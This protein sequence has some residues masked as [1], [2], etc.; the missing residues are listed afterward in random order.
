MSR[1]PNTGGVEAAADEL[2]LRLSRTAGP[3]VKAILDGHRARLAEPPLV[4]IAGRV[5]AGKS[6]LVNALI[7]ARVA[8]TAAR[9]TTAV[10][11]TYR[12]GAPARA[13]ATMKDGSSQRVTM[14]HDGPDLAAL[15]A[16][17]VAHLTVH[18]QEA[19]LRRFSIL[20]TPG[21]GS[22][23][24]GNSE[25]T[26][27]ALTTAATHGVRPDVVLY[28]VR[29]MFRA[30]DVAF[31]ERFAQAWTSVADL[32]AQS[33]VLAVLSH[34]DNYGA[35]PWGAVDPM[36]E[37]QR[38]AAELPDT[39]GVLAG[40]VAVSGLLAETVRTG[41]LRER[42]IRA[43]R[44]L[45]DVDDDDLQY[46][47]L[48]GPVPD[49]PQEGLDRLTALLGAYGVR[50]G[51]QHA[52]SSPGLLD[53]VEELSGMRPL[54]RL[55]EDVLGASGGLARVDSILGEVTTMARRER[56]GGELE[57]ALEEALAS[58]EFHRLDQWRALAELRRASPGHE[59][60]P[61]LEAL[62]R[63]PDR[64]PSRL[65]GVGDTE[66]LALAGRFQALAGTAGTG[67]EAQAARVLS[68]SMILLA[69]HGAQWR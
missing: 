13:E 11:T 22:A 28:V 1:L 12:F 3:G 56:W 9:E 66:P 42:D 38:A 19:A 50:H 51:R 43:L 7:G 23:M 34:A 63:Q 24:T 47:G 40:A 20:D 6:T 59:L 46:A 31:L 61:V 27:L 21:L 33:G 69:T 30:D 39:H 60:I 18:V 8:P 32:P 16:D 25:H 44:L 54:E 45:R 67:A 36:Q 29:D 65:A 14:G 68:R 26:E 64:V 58:P 2:L 52:D 53:W 35:G 55:L 15:G 5:S 10:L 17:D 49:V 57:S 37:A 62:Q 41:L 4:L 48:L